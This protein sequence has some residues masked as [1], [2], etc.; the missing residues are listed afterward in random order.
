MADPREYHI[1]QNEELVS[2]KRRSA[3]MPLSR[4]ALVMKIIDR[5]VYGALA[6]CGM[7]IKLLRPLFI[8]DSRK[9]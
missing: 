2:L 9:G 7:C 1:L 4:E 8:D 6:N 3:H 5:D